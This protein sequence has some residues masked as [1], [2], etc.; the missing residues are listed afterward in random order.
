MKRCKT[1]KCLLAILLLLGSLSAAA[2]AQ[3]MK[4]VVIDN[5][6][7]LPIANARVLVSRPGG[8]GVSYGVLTDARGR[9]DTADAVENGGF[10]AGERVVIDIV[11]RGY[12]LHE[13]RIALPHGE[14]DVEYRL[15]P[16]HR[17]GAGAKVPR[18]VWIK[19][20]LIEA[21]GEGGDDPEYP[22]E[23]EPVVDELKS[24]FKFKYYRV[25]GRAEAM[26]M[27]GSAMAFES[28]PGDGDSPFEVMADLGFGDGYIRLTQL[29]VHVRSPR[30]NPA[31]ASTWDTGSTRSISTTLNL[32]EGE[33]V[34]LGASR[35]QASKGS[36]ILAISA[37]ATASSN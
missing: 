16:T 2:S 18:Q 6:T 22:E 7:G 21:A 32:P 36:L 31:S 29:S 37:A 11:A 19:V 30:K 26:G 20:L 33:M 3:S 25:I 35:G 10:E 28:D 8:E 13:E 23:I 1:S 5:D 34:I 4:G 17:Q 27:E 15:K 9:F 24:L 14:V 12:E